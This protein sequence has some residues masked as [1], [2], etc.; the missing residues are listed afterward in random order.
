MNQEFIINTPDYNSF[1]DEANDIISAVL[2]QINKKDLLN[3]NGTY[4]DQ[5]NSLFVPFDSIEVLFNFRNML[6]NEILPTI[7]ETEDRMMPLSHNTLNKMVSEIINGCDYYI[8][9]YLPDQILFYL[10]DLETNNNFFKESINDLNIYYKAYLKSEFNNTINSQTILKTW[11]RYVKES[12]INKE[13]ISG[14]GFVNFINE[15]GFVDKISNSP[16]HIYDNYK[17]F[18]DILPNEEYMSTILNNY[19]YLKYIDNIDNILEKIEAIKEDAD[20][21]IT[22]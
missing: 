9:E 11:N 6:K 5:G 18:N 17:F 1:C 3:D 13:S 15:Y 20:Y 10:Q 7:N 8:K 2:I 14:A 4:I 21:E 19:E 12:K 16:L 22:E